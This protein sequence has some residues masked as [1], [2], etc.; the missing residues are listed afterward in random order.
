MRSV[1]VQIVSEPE[2]CQGAWI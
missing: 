1:A 2:I